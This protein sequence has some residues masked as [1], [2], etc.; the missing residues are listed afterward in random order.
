MRAES[1]PP[2]RS[3]APQRYPAANAAL[4][5]TTASKVDADEIRSWYTP[6]PHEFQA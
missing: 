6:E 5:T 2:W 3:G 4:G 1:S